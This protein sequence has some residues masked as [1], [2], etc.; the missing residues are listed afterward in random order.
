MG[1]TFNIL[2]I[3]TL[4]GIPLAMMIGSTNAALRQ[5]LQSADHA[6]MMD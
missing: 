3:V 4:C 2:M 1:L 5:Q 6:A